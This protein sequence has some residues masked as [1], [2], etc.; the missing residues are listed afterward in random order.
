MFQIATMVA[1][2][3]VLAGVGWSLFSA[4]T[5]SLTDQL[6][7]VADAATGMLKVA[8]VAGIGAMAVVEVHK[9]MFR[10]RGEFHLQ[11]LKSYGKEDLVDRVVARNRDK[12]H[13]GKSDT[14]RPSDRQR[15]RNAT[16]I[17]D[18]PLEQVIAALGTAAERELVA[19][20]QLEAEQADR[21]RHSDEPRPTSHRDLGSRWHFSWLHELINSV[22]IPVG[23]V[24]RDP[25]S[26]LHD[27]YEVYIE[28][29]PPDIREAT[30]SALDTLL[31]RG[32]STWR[33][34][35]RAEAVFVAGAIGLLALLLGDSGWQTTFAVSVTS[36]IWGGYFAWLSR[37]VAAA[38]GRWRN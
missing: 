6:G 28:T 34:R 36:A 37:D 7:D 20:F 5:S 30:E 35:M 3:V 33:Y 22:G 24:A 29:L 23:E 27:D 31:I 21:V 19:L 2:L 32:R 16:A 25:R 13:V 14:A 4:T 9:H 12:Q 8:L 10:L 11:F 26:A 15:D 17:L 1:L 18:M 38:I